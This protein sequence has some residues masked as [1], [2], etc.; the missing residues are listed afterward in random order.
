MQAGRDVAIA[1]RDAVAA[2][3]ERLQAAHDALAERDDP[4]LRRQRAARRRANRGKLSAH[5]PRIEIVLAPEDTSCPCCRAAMV[6]IGEDSSERLDVIP[7]QFRVLVTRRPKFAFR[8]CPGVVV[9]QPAPTRRIEGGI[10]TEG[11]VAHVLVARQAD[12]MPLYRQVQGWACQGVVVDRS[13]LASWVGTAAAELAPVMTRLKQ[14]VLASDRIFADKT[15]A[16]VL[17]P[18]RGSTKIGYFWAKLA[19]VPPA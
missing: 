12:H 2:E 8:A 17:D 13:T 4:A 5:L 16:P 14:L 9:Q 18:G 7:V 19:K 11:T 10:P 1:E 6:E 3:R 15:M